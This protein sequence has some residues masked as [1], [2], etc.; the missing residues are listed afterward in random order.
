MFLES[1]LAW[2]TALCGLALWL[3]VAGPGSDRSISER[4]LIWCL[5]G[6]MLFASIPRLV[7]NYDPSAGLYAGQ[8]GMVGMVIT[9]YII[10]MLCGYRIIKWLYRYT[11]FMLTPREYVGNFFAGHRRG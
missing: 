9:R 7:E 1:H 5:G 11:K 4:L 8:I 2:A 3:L 10:L 6:T